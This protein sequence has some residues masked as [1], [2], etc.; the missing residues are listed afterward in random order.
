ML[1]ERIHVSTRSLYVCLVLLLVLAT[2][3]GLYFGAIQLQFFQMNAQ[4]QLIFYELRLPR[5]L[6]SL[7]LGANLAFCGA[8]SQGLFRNA[9]V[10][11]S[12]IGV[13]AGASLGAS[14]VIVGAISLNTLILKL[15]VVAIGAFCGGLLTV[16]LVYQLA[17]RL[18]SGSVLMMLLVGIAVTAFAS[19]VTGLLDFYA[20]SEQLRR[21]SLWRMGG[22]QAA[23]YSAVGLAAVVLMFL[24]GYGF[25]YARTLDALLLGES[26]ARHLG[27]DVDKVKLHLIVLIAFG[28]GTAVALGGTIAFVG[29]IVPHM[30][31]VFVGPGHRLLL[32]AS[33]MGGGI[34]LSVADTCS[35][36][37]LA[38]TEL[39]VGLLTALLGAPFFVLLL[40][41][42]YAR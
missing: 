24:F 39:P 33:A 30:L 25:F 36:T 8:I 7:L 23:D 2:L 14:L 21:L 40:R 26:E 3:G 41:Q 35:R 38:P 11:P 17:T 20:D 5:V 34:L 13:T 42:N 18:N 22:L 37:V 6:L 9:L 28:T 15:P 27:I 31:R 4:Q 1:T 12:L 10:D 16:I 29:L 19:A 32:P